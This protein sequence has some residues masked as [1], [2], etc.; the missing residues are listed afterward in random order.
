MVLC[1]AQPHLHHPSFLF[2]PPPSSS[3]FCSYSFLSDLLLLHSSYISVSSFTLYCLT[4]QSTSGSPCPLLH[5][6]FWSPRYED[7]TVFEMM[8]RNGLN[9]HSI[10]QMK[11]METL[12]RF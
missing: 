7:T 1:E 10:Y 8:E 2:L 4:P 5:Q 9:Q 11:S 3:S 12:Y 6:P